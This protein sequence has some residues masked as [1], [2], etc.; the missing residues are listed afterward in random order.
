MFLF[1]TI[2]LTIL[3]AP[4]LL[5]YVKLRNIFM[6]ELKNHFDSKPKD[7]K[8]SNDPLVLNLTSKQLFVWKV[9]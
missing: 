2:Y 6:V 1:Y 5:L 4:T 7:H 9:T 3:L 8:G